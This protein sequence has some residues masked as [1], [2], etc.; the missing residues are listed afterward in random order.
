[1][2]P[3]PSRLEFLKDIFSPFGDITIRKM[4]GG[5]GIYCDGAIFAIEA[6]DAV[7]FKV[8]DVTRDEFEVAELEPF[9]IEMNGKIGTMSYYNAPEEIYDDADA[10]DHWTRLALGAA[11]RNKRPKKRAKAKPR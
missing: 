5:A 7:W 10:L 8:D 2:A 9:T 4:F 11:A 6:D 1:M 3:S